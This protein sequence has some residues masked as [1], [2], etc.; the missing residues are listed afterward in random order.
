MIVDYIDSHRSRF[1]VEPIC[2]VLSE[3][4]LPIAPSTYYERRHPPVTDA[5]L[6]DAYLANALATLHAESWSVHGTRKRWTAAH[7]AGFD[8]RRNRVARLMRSRTSPARSG[9]GP[10]AP[11]PHAATPPRH[12]LPTWCTAALT[13]PGD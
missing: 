6:E 8:V 9:T 7:R 11:P 12:A 3:H 13:P 4:G 10:D 5:E 1:G 2:A